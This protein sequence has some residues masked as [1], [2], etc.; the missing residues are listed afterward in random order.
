M[1][2]RILTIEDVLM[3][4]VV[5]ILPD[6]KGL[7]SLMKKQVIRLYLGVDPTGSQLHLGHA[8]VLRKLRQFQD[9]GHE[10]I[11]VFGTFTAQIGDPSGK[12]MQREL[13][14]LRDIQ[15][16]MATYKQQAAKI[17]DV[18][19]TKIRLN[20]DWLGK[21]KFNDVLRLA[22]QFTVAQLMGRD[23]FQK[24]VEKG[25]E[26]W[27]S[28]LLYPLMQGY[29]SVAMDVDLEVGGTDQTF[30]MLVGRRL[31]KIYNKKEKYVLT[32]PLLVGLDGRKMS[33]SYGNTVNLM[34]DA[35]DM[36]GKLMSLHDEHIID[37]FTLCTDVLSK[38]VNDLK[39]KLQK[40]TVSPRDAKAQL[41]KE[42]VALY[43][44]KAAASTAEKE[45]QRV[46]QE[47]KAPSKIREFSATKE[48]IS[49]VDLVRSTG[50][51]LSNSEA[52]RVI[53]QG[54]VKLDGV[55]HSD[56]TEIVQR[57]RGMVVQVGKRKFAKDT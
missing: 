57:R 17:L 32:T 15:K 42:I 36:Y 49:I 46:F 27:V 24:R 3:Q 31:Q 8:V 30:N 39:Q 6:R 45:F 47:K 10:V 16:N 20:H 13:L 18:K 5:E 4:N 12:D 37:Y 40:G 53:G 38:Q 29:D 55:V 33:K 54:G 23:M 19:K 7:A 21:L 56:T 25:S 14:S 26:V 43:H 52:R 28:E 44:G 41:A 2:K 35:K 22:S 34:D 50:F 1:V 9:L 11:L 51:V 48:K